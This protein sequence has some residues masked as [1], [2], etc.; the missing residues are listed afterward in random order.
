MNPLRSSVA[1]GRRF[2]GTSSTLETTGGVKDTTIFYCCVTA[3]AIFAKI[4]I[5][6]S[7]VCLET[8]AELRDGERKNNEA[9]WDKFTLAAIKE[10]DFAMFDAEED[11]EKDDP[12]AYFID[13]ELK[14]D[15]EDESD[16][17][18]TG[19]EDGEDTESGE[20][21]NPS[22]DAALP[23][24]A[25]PDMTKNDSPQAKISLTR[26]AAAGTSAAEAPDVK[27]NRAHNLTSNSAS[28]NA[29]ET[30]SN[31][32]DSMEVETSQR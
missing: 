6:D 29:K 11:V 17:S 14:V 25:L 13:E 19:D 22:G 2:I 4:A 20:V 28:D 8:S 15:N 31:E 12:M 24:C 27:E 10:D 30:D 32:T 26:E 16:E 5:L 1:C 21:K 23:E 18:S 3:A 9:N 7:T